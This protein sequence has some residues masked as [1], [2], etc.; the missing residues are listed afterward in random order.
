MSEQENDVEHRLTKVETGFEAHVKSCDASA[1]ESKW[2]NRFIGG[3]VILWIINQTLVHLH[4][5]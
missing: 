5:S 1:K 4:F 3:A 2:W